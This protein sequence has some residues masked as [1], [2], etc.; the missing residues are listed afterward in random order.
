MKS[1]SGNAVPFCV[2][3]IKKTDWD[4]NGLT[5]RNRSNIVKM[6][7]HIEVLPIDNHKAAESARRSRPEPSPGILG[8]QR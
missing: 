3:P 8:Q 6:K 1:L 7:S 4:S 5:G 2:F